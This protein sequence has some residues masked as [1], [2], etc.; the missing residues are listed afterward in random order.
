MARQFFT[1]VN[2]TLLILRAYIPVSHGRANVERA[3]PLWQ[4]CF[5]FYSLNAQSQDVSICLFLLFNN[6]TSREFIT[7]PLVWHFTRMHIYFYF[8]VIIG[9]LTKTGQWYIIRF[10]IP[11]MRFHRAKLRIYSMKSLLPKVSRYFCT[12]FI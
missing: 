12:L 8:F 11:Y 4:K 7:D 3:V 10:S 5:I 1:L 2:L 6:S 9:T